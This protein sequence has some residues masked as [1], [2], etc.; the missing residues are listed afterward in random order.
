MSNIANQTHGF[1][2]DYEQ[3]YTN[4]EYGLLNQL[5]SAHLVPERYNKA[6][7]PW[8]WNLSL[9]SNPYFPSLKIDVTVVIRKFVCFNSV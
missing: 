6:D 2:I 7:L 3:I 8:L 1:T 5:I 9:G 4:L